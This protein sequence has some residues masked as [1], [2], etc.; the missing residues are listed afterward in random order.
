MPVSISQTEREVVAA[1][2]A[3]GR[4]IVG[5]N[6]PRQAVAAE[7]GDQ[8][9]L[10]GFGGLVGAGRQRDREAQMVIEHGMAVGR[11]ARRRDP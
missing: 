5:G 2:V 11:H 8:P 6:A 9:G 7:G 3:P 10:Y 1:A 4:A